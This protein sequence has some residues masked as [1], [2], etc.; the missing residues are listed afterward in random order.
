VHHSVLSPKVRINSYAE[1][2]DS[3]LFENVQIG[4]RCRIRKAIIDK[5]VEIPAETTIGFNPE[6]DRKRFHVTPAGVVVIPK[7][8][9]VS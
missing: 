4:R 2:T 3:I 7:G 6:E 5:N 9:R 8:M 1:I